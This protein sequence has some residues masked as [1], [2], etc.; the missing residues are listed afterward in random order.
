M[1][2]TWPTALSLSTSRAAVARSGIGPM[3]TR[4]REEDPEPLE[5]T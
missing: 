1:V 5:M 2:A 4:N 3:R